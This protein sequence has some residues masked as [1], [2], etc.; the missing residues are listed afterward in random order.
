MNQPPPSGAADSYQP[1][2]TQ[3]GMIFQALFDEEKD[4]NH[5]QLLVG[6]LA[7]GE[8]EW[9]NKAWQRAYEKLPALRSYFQWEGVEEPQLHIAAPTKVPWQR[10]SGTRAELEAF[11]SAD[12]ALIW[13]LR[14][15]PLLRLTWFELTDENTATLVWSFHHILIDG[16][17]IIGVL[18]GVQ[19]FVHAYR[20]GR[21]E[22][23]LPIADFDVLMRKLQARDGSKDKA[24]WQEYLR[25]FQSVNELP[26]MLRVPDEAAP[27]R[28]YEVTR[29]GPSL[30]RLKKAAKSRGLTLGTIVQ[31]AWCFLLAK[32]TGESDIVVGVA[33][34]G[35][36]FHPQA[37]F[38]VGM[39]MTTV[40]MRSQVDLEM[41]VLEWLRVFREG[42]LGAREHE[43]CSLAEIQALTP[44]PS[45]T[46]LFVSLV[47]IENDY[48]N[49]SK[50]NLD[51]HWR[52]RTVELRENA[53]YPLV[54]TTHANHTGDLV[55]TLGADLRSIDKS[56][57]KPALDRFAQLIDALLEVLEKDSKLKLAD[58]EWLPE[59]ERSALR[60]LYPSPAPAPETS[61]TIDSLFREQ[62]QRV[63]DLVAVVGPKGRLTYREL[64]R[65]SNQ[66]AH[67]LKERRVSTGD[68][69]AVCLDRDPLMVAALLGVLKAGAAYVPVD[70]FLPAERLERI[71]KLAAP[72]ATLTLGR[73]VP[74]LPESLNDVITVDRVSEQ[75]DFCPDRA[76]DAKTA[77]YAVFTSGTTGQ[78]K[79]IVTTHTNLVS[80]YQSWREAYRLEEHKSHL[81]MAGYTFDVFSGDF[82]RALLSGGKLVLC[83]P[84]RFLNPEELAQLIQ[85]E[86]VDIAEFVPLVL[87]TL[88]DH[89]EL[90]QKK[91]TSLRTVIA[92]SD[93]WYVSEYRRFQQIFGSEVRLINSYGLSEC[94]ID[95][96][97]YEG[98]L[99]D[100]GD[101]KVLPIGRPF[102][103][104][105]V[106]VVEESG[107]DAGINRVGELWIG[108]PGVTDGYLGDPNS[109]RFFNDDEGVKWYKTGDL[110]R[111]SP[112]GLISLVGRADTQV[113][114]Q[115]YR[116]ELGE[117]EAALMLHPDVADCVVVT[118][119]R[120]RGERFLVAYIVSNGGSL[121]V[122]ELG[123][124]TKKHLPYYM[125][126]RAFVQLQEIPHTPNGKVD[127]K[128]LPA[129]DDARA[130]ILHVEYQAPETPTQV[131]IAQIWSDLLGVPRVGLKDNFF[132]LGGH[133][134]LAVRL[135]ARIN[136]F[137][138][139]KLALP[140]L[141]GAQTVEMMAQLVDSKSQGEQGLIQLQDGP[142]HRPALFWIHT[143]GGG[144]GGGFFRYQYLCQ[145][146]SEPRRSY[147]I[148]A[149][150]VPFRR[151][152]EMAAHYAELIKQAQGSG[153]YHILGYCFGGTVA[154]EVARQ[155]K[156]DGEEVGVVGLIDAEARLAVPPPSSFGEVVEF[157]LNIF[158]WLWRFLRQDIRQSLAWFRRR[159]IPMLGGAVRGDL[160]AFDYDLEDFLEAHEQDPE[161]RP[162]V[163]AHW[164]AAGRYE[165]LR[166]PG[167]VLLVRSRYQAIAQYQRAMG[168]KNLADRVDVRILDY[169][170]GDLLNDPARD[171]VAE[172][173]EKKIIESESSAGRNS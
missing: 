78:P 74:A 19:A 82:A 138:D 52:E 96:T 80:I 93:V 171:I 108:G 158:S 57:V 9:W 162:F 49:E 95:S 4:L 44:I 54:L 114:V 46:D 132:E 84:E 33:R 116:V 122:E 68:F 1:T 118:H 66:I 98:P 101:D 161:Y 137:A 71:F 143:L 141:I 170:H 128:A 79:G 153:P 157:L 32:S 150:A 61:I 21:P 45:G 56:A 154:Y 24:F 155:L 168:W 159:L 91:L 110:A 31:C 17:S 139:P 72:R 103:N 163:E 39:F 145:Q 106:R 63:P 48:L 140:A 26:G 43:H 94:T 14:E 169:S 111:L 142:E 2:A 165:P 172:I 166:F 20:E 152:D 64:D 23:Q 135:F 164:A 53:G 5:E 28:P 173:I 115:G 146:F 6:G 147:G 38:G 60:A 144:G 62:V 70:R 29:V 104:S 81:Q 47:A 40:P 126:P 156:E 130:E 55:M 119:E 100:G 121:D 25:G 86:E 131:R 107:R 148:Q 123:A 42:T 87:R 69:V 41:D 151:I 97:F 58:L 124:A 76:H 16:R 13:D 59:E 18:G 3:E 112:D 83:E 167:E 85:S 75:P 102:N 36:N 35:R 105:I 160:S 125:N 27:D 133:S 8:E 117:V 113:K 99:P 7:P 50:L 22:P 51:E 67:L 109:P 11:T 10:L 92:G 88:V 136:E 90:S 120:A 65:L 34:A 12:R 30:N 77:C 15:A 37:M 129:P 89:L 134:L 149:P 127:K 73:F